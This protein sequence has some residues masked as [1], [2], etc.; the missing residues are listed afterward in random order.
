MF[1][2]IISQFL[3]CYVYIVIIR[4]LM[5]WFSPQ[6]NNPIYKV[7][8]A[9]TEPFLSRIRG[10][11]PDLGGIDFSPFILIMLVLLIKDF[12]LR[13]LFLSS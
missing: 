13:N 12:L 6:T 3:N 5:S 10:F 8:V 1:F 11:L 7:L 4:S 2:R 9:M